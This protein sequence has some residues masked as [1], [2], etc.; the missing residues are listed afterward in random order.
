MYMDCVKRCDDDETYGGLQKRTL[1]S[2]SV[3][4]KDDTN[5]FLLKSIEVASCD[6]SEQKSKKEIGK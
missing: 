1:V 4:W 5:C 3:C 2:V 6:I